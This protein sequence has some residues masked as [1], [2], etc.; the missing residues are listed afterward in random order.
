MPEIQQIPDQLP[1]NLKLKKDQLQAYPD[2]AAAQTALAAKDINKYYVLPA[3]FIQT[4][5]LL[6]VDSNFSVFNSLEN[7]DYFE[8][9]IRLNLVGD[10]NLAHDDSLDCRASACPHLSGV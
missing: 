9:L 2:Q 5:H 3:D 8:Y 10:A 6:V 4:G 7:N 1:A